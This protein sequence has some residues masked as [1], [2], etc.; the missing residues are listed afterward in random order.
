MT[1][2]RFWRLPRWQMLLVLSLARLA[3]GFQFQAIASVAPVLQDR[4][5]FSLGGIGW[6]IGLYLLPGIALAL[7]SG[8]LGARYGDRRI[9]AIGL[10]LMTVGGAVMALADAPGMLT[11]GRL[12]AGAGAVLFNVIVQKMIADWFAGHE[13]VLA[14]AII[15]NTWPIGMALALFT[16]GG[17]GTAYGA[18]AAFAITSAFALLALVLLLAFYRSPAEV[19]GASKPSLGAIN[20]GEWLLLALAGG[21]WMLFN[22]VFAGIAS[23]LPAFLIERGLDAVAAN[24]TTGLST[25]AVTISIVLGGIANQ[26]WQRPGLITQ[27]G[28][29][30]S[31]L[32]FALLLAGAD[33]TVSVLL[34]GVLAGLAAGP[35]VSLPAQFLRPQTRATGLGVS[36]TLYYLGMTLLPGP[37]GGLAARFGSTDAILAALIAMTIATALLTATVSVLRKR[38]VCAPLAEGRMPGAAIG[39][40]EQ[41]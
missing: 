28:L 13:I 33:V 22:V 34:L 27:I 1:P 14:M 12:L 21:A 3:M 17:V 20:R 37:I 5:G 9:A 7:P 32:G 6:L 10:L 39:Q 40:A 35:I 24:A 8:I 26:R 30:G 23:F 18:G 16:L 41:G 11:T 15:I 36:L 38:G 25:V 31:V 19:A 2:P 29:V 4:F